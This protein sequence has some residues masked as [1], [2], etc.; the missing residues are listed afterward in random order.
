[1]SRVGFLHTAEVHVGTF[2]ALVGDSAETV[3]VVESHLLQRARTDGLTPAVEAGVRSALDELHARGADVVVCTC[4]TLGPVAES[5][6]SDVPV[7]RVDRPMARTA[8]AGG[9]RIGVVAAVEST[10]EPTRLL[11]QD[12]ARRAGAEPVLT[13]V[14]VP[15][16]WASF[17][18]GDTAA[19]LCA[20]ADAARALADTVDVVVLAQA[21]MAGAVDLLEDLAVPVLASPRLAVESALRAAG[22]RPVGRP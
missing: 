13:E 7:L 4:S 6:A 14:L 8:V 2:D 3:H 20:I 11:L 1:M 19:Y 12:E 18:A 15:G 21:S 5:V 16:A 9:A 17:E 22:D 10:L